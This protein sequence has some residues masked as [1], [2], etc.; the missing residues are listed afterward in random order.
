MRVG[1]DRV[2]EVFTKNRG[3]DKVR[4]GM[5]FLRAQHLL[6]VAARRHAVA[7]SDA[8]RRHHEAQSPRLRMSL[9]VR[10]RVRHRRTKARGRD[11]DLQQQGEHLRL[12]HAAGRAGREVLL[13][14]N[15][16]ATPRECDALVE[17][18]PRLHVVHRVVIGGWAQ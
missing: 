4:F 11:A 5:V 1:T 12:G 6:E 14:T 9:Q 10:L 8:N 15:E 18:L 7:K 2:V 13:G 16:I 17:E 3:E